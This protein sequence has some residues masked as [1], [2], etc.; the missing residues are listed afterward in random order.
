MSEKKSIARAAGSVSA[1]TAISRVMGFIRD[2]TLAFYFGASGLSD[3]FFLAFKIPNLLRELFAEGAMSASVIP[4]LTGYRKDDPAGARK[5]V[6]VLLGFVLVVVGG[7][8][9]LGVVFA[10]PIVSVIGYGLLKDPSK[11]GTFASTVALARTMMSFLLFVS[12]AS[13]LMASLNTRR[14]FFIPALSPAMFNLTLIISIIALAS[15]MEHPI[16]AAGIGVVI[17][18]FVQ[19]IFQAPKHR[20]EGGSLLPSFG[21]SHPGLKRIGI[22][23]LPVMAGMSV[24]QVN[25]IVGAFL[26]AFL[27]EGSITYLFYCFI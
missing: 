19:F 18:G 5:L 3:S 27:P 23:M 22:L 13:V 26:A 20:A 9:V 10:G 25:I 2:M 1:A 24:S 17:G 8:C 12:L 6:R 14:V 7:I 4:V 21:F 15:R 11:A 16:M